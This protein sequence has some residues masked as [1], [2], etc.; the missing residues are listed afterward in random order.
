MVDLHVVTV[1]NSGLQFCL[2]LELLSFRTRY[3][4]EVR[5]GHTPLHGR[6]YYQMM[7]CLG[8]SFFLAVILA[9]KTV[10]IHY[11]MLFCLLPMIM[12]CTDIK[13]ISC[14]AGKNPFTDAR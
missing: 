13:N 4:S 6:A 1:M 7:E 2:Q 11:V 12:L 9:N 5:K 14:A 3:F 10:Y 8:V